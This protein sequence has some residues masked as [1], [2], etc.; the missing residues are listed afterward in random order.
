MDLTFGERVY[1]VGE[2]GGSL[3]LFGYSGIGVLDSLSKTLEFGKP[4]STFPTPIPLPRNPIPLPRF[5]YS[6]FHFNIRII[7]NSNIIFHFLNK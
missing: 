3:E 7:P 5:K 2:N 6:N 1:A 4:A